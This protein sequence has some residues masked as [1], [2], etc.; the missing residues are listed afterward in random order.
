MLIHFGQTV[1]DDLRYGRPRTTNVDHFVGHEANHVPSHFTALNLGGQIYV[2]EIPGGNPSSS[3]LLVGPR[4]IGG[5]ADLAP[6][7]LSFVGDSQHPDLLIEAGGIQT[8]F[9]NTGSTYEPGA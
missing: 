6:V 7:T 1:A 9:R 3:R 8:R 5:G 2:I 4:L